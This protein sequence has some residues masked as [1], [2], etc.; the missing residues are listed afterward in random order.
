MRQ[1]K[2]ITLSAVVGLSLICGGNS[3]LAQVV[4]IPGTVTASCTITT[5]SD[6]AL[7]E[8]PSPLA[9]K[10]IAAGGD[11]GTV[12]VKCNDG[13]K[14]LNLAINTGSSV[15]YN[16]TAKIQL[17]AANATGPFA[18]AT[19]LSASS[20]VVAIPNPTLAVGDTA[21]IRAEV[22]APAGKLLKAANDYSLVVNATITP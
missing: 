19:T 14:N 13:T 5:S 10:L 18:I 15:L 6:G 21:K 11:R 2:L 12:V 4:N 20:I 22:S 7:S 1:A 3:A 8:D 9:T 17:T 16:G